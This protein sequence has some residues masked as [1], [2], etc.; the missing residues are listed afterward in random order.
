M[1]PSKFNLLVTTYRRAEHEAGAELF[2]LLVEL[3]DKSPKIELTGISGLLAVETSIPAD[4][5]I[6]EVRRIIESEPWRIRYLLRLIPIEYVVD[7]DLS[8]IKRAVEQMVDRIKDNESFRITVEKRHTNLSSKDI[9]DA[10]ASVVHRSVNLENPD[11]IVLV[12]VVDGK[13][14]L[15]I[16]KP[17]QI[18]SVT[19]MKRGV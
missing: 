11:W 7:T 4:R 16:I 18:L 2:S 3:G 8:A 14:G 1:I 15:S 10:V 13:T 5:V 17:H 12:E 6:E 9:I 19:S